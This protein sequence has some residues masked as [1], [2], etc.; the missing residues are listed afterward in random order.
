MALKTPTPGEPARRSSSSKGL[1]AT[2]ARERGSCDRDPSQ[3]VV[4]R[5]SGSPCEALASLARDSRSDRGRGETGA[6]LD[7]FSPS[8]A[9]LPVP[10]AVPM[11]TA[12]AAQGPHRASERPRSGVS[13]CAA[14]LEL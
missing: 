13:I 1:G 4:A 5:A 9:P 6:L 8:P 14:S 7:S 3:C 12:R 11:P 10:P 2:S